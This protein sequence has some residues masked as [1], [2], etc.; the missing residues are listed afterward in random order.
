MK[1]LPEGTL[2]RI[3]DEPDEVLSEDREHLESC[4]VCQLVSRD[5]KADM[6]ILT[7]MFGP[8]I[9]A[10]DTEA[11]WSRLNAEAETE[12]EPAPEKPEAGPQPAGARA[13]LAIGRVFVGVGTFVLLFVAYQLLGTNLVTNNEQKALAAELQTQWMSNVV[14]DTPDLGDGVG[15]IKIPKIGVDRVVVEGVGVSDLKKGPGHYPGT[16]MP[17]QIGNTVI[18]GHRTTYGAPFNRLDELEIGDEILVYD[19]TGPFKYVVTE[20]KV[21][22]PSAVEVLDPSSDARLTLTTCHPKFSAKERLIIVAQLEGTPTGTADQ[23]QGPG[24]EI[25]PEA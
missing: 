13:L 10:L 18:S 1:H 4:N 7:E 24:L 3:L 12:T 21:V 2:R 11:A 9:D 23:P 17:G 15:L 5:V 20:N 14:E 16:A 6:D 25:L 22:K 19:R 8:E